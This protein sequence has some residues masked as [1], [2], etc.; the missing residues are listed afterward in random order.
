MGKKSVFILV[1]IIL[2]TVVVLWFKRCSGDSKL[3]DRIAVVDTLYI[4]NQVPVVPIDKEVSDVPAVGMIEKVRELKPVRQEKKTTAKVNEYSSE[5]IIEV[6]S[7]DEPVIS[8][9]R[10]E[11]PA[12]VKEDPVTVV[13]E[14]EPQKEVDQQACKIWNPKLHLKTNVIGWGMGMMNLA[15]ELDFSQHWSFQLPVYYSAW[16]YFETT[17]KFRTFAVQPELRFWSSED[18]QGLFAGAHMG[19]A[20]YNVAWGGEY[21]YQDHDRKTPAVGGGLSVGYRKSLG[22]GNRW[23]VEC[24]L[25]VGVYSL[26]YDKFYNTSNVKEGLMVETVKKTFVGIDQAS[27]SFSYSFD[28]SKKGGQ[29]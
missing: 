3:P 15:V 27:V 12:E 1:F 13:K 26:H 18:H 22:K 11:K 8:P 16:N 29:R 21:R 6:E 7:V 24:L 10:E 2:L 20:Y 4:D 28:L 5:E 17:V 9:A 14:N 25:G 23:N 19:M